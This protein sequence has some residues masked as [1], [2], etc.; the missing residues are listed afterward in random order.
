MEAALEGGDPTDS[1]LEACPVKEIELHD[2]VTDIGKYI[3]KMMHLVDSSTSR[4]VF[5]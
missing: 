2:S 1:L 5:D 4:V 3:R